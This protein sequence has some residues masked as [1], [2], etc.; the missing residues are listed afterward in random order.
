M[1]LLDEALSSDLFTRVVLTEEDERLECF[2]PVLLATT[3][4][5][6]LGVAILEAEA[7]GA[8]PKQYHGCS[9]RQQTIASLPGEYC[10]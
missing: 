6:V 10:C 7:V 2:R 1:G 5:M 4:V 8:A 3:I 9:K